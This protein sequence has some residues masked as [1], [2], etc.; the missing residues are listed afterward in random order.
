SA[1]TLAIYTGAAEALA[2]HCATDGPDDPVEL[3]RA[4]VAE[5]LA[6]YATDHAP[7]TVSMTYRAL[8][9]FCR[10]IADEEDLP[11]SAMAKMKPP[12]VPDKPVPVLT[13]DQLKALL[14]GASGRDLVSRRDTA[15]IRLFLDTGCRRAEIAGL[16]L[17][18]VDFGA[19]VIHVIGKGRRSRAVPFGARTGTALD[20]YVRLRGKDRQ[21]ALPALWLSEKGRGALS[22]DGI[23]QMLWRR[24]EA[25]GIERLHPHQFRHTA[26]HTWLN[27]GGGE[28]DLMRNMGWKSSAMVRRYGASVADERARE[29]HRRLRLGDRL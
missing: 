3:D 1:R 9:Q 15:I 12:A 22:A 20:R 7:S 8:Q 19:D 10:W 27:A 14:R 5:F 28:S 13:D 23:R 16:T 2:R 18:D 24:G 6:V 21:A 4:A 25:V 11:A 26:A 29:A 17:A